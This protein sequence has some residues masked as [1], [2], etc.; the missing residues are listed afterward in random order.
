M[1]LA[2]DTDKNID[3]KGTLIAPLSL[4]RKKKKID[5]KFIVFQQSS[6]IIELL[7]RYAHFLQIIAC[8]RICRERGALA[9]DHQK[10]VY[11]TSK[12]NRGLVLEFF[13]FF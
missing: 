11:T 12:Y 7:Q 6:K 1:I 3:V 2:D 8:F 10:N 9:N 13:F 4:F 5:M